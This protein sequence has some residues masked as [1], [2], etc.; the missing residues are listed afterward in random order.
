MV[1][2]NELTTGATVD[3]RNPLHQLSRTDRYLSAGDKTKA[4]EVVLK[5]R[6]VP[7]DDP[8]VFTG[9]AQLCQPCLRV[10]FPPTGSFVGNCQP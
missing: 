8:A 3:S 4:L 9:W 10:C 7:A 6:N 2:I 1:D 5:W